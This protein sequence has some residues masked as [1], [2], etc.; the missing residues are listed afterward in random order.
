MR[1]ETL[2]DLRVATLAPGEPAPSGVHWAR[3]EDPSREEVRRRTAEGWFHKPCYVTWV[4]RT[5]A[6]LDDYIRDAFRAG[7]RN[8]PRKLLRDVPSRY[9]FERH[10]RGEGMKAF[11]ELYR[12][13]IVAKPRGRDRVSEHEEGFGEGWTGFHLYDGS[14]L[15]AGVLVHSVRGHDS[16]AYGAFDPERRRELDLEHFLI[17]KVLER[18]AAHD[19]PWVSLGMDTNRYGHHLPLGLPAYKL[20][21]GFTPLPWEPSGR[22]VAR[23]VSFEVFEDGLFFFGYEGAGLTGQLF[24]REAPDLRP[25]QH[26][27]APPV[28]T[29]RIDGSSFRPWEFSPGA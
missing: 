22:E 3:V 15:A 27:N 12:R 11:V 21:I 18:A 7:T 4:L 28:K 10:E 13:T 19:A 23:P 8:K 2:F 25:F 24:T 29:W 14:A 17:M 6:S 5:P 20:R 9:R 26:H 1:E 16:V